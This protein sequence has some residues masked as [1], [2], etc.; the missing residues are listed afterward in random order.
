MGGVELNDSD[1]YGSGGG[2]D[3]QQA[4][5]RQKQRSARR[6]DQ[7]DARITELKEKEERRQEAM[8]KALGLSHIKPG[9]KIKIQP[10]K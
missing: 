10:R 8:L 4:L 3:F 7:R 9:Q 1:L 5:A 6:L 2:S